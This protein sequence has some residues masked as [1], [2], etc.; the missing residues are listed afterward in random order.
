[1]GRFAGNKRVIHAYSAS[2]PAFA[3]HVDNVGYPCN[4]AQAEVSVSMCVYVCLCVG[5]YKYERGAIV[6]E[7]LS[8]LESVCVCVC[9]CVCAFVRAPRKVI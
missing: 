3:L 4:V 6:C 2:F 7:R 8:V 1:M 5:G 9:M